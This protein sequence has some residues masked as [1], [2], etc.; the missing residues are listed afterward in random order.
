VFGVLA[1]YWSALEAEEE[2][3]AVTAAAAPHAR[4]GD[5]RRLVSDLA[6]L[7]SVLRPPRVVQSMEMIAYDPERAAAW[8]EAQGVRVVRSG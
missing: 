6:S 7:A 2:Q 1:Q 5:Y 8:F 3:R 4:P